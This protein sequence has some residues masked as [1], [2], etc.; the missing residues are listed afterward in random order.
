MENK[1]TETFVPTRRSFLAG[2][3]ALGASA[4][5]AGC[6]DSGTVNAGAPGPSPTYPAVT[7]GDN[8]ILNFALNLEYLEAEFYL[9]AVTGKGVPGP[10]AG[11]NPG[12]VTGAQAIKFTDPV[13]Q[14]FFVE[15]AQDELNHIRVLRAAISGNGG[16]PVSRPVIDYT[17]GFSGAA[18]AAGIASTFSPFNDPDSFAVGAFTFIDVGVAAYTGAAPLLVSNTLLDAA[19]GI[20]A[21][22]GYHSGTIRSMIAGMAAASGSTTYLDIANKISALRAKL[23]NG[24]D[25]MLST[26]SVVYADS[27]ALGWAHTASE[28]LHIVYG[29]GGGAGVKSGGFFPQGLNGTLYTTTA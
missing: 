13:M 17:A 1:K 8:D 3:G 26:T 11:T 25:T 2:A 4:L 20:Q 29:T 14:Q 15:I 22:E 24:K 21:A 6:S 5:V 7:F 28:T 23:A 9:T 18:A 10:D 19:A 16:T 27:N 12:T